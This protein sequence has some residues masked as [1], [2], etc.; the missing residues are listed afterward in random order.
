MK[1]RPTFAQLRQHKELL[2]INPENG[3]RFRVSL[4]S[5]CDCLWFVRVYPYQR[6]PSDADNPFVTAHRLMPRDA[7]EEWLERLR[8]AR[9]G[10]EQKD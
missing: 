10:T 6:H 4:R 5:W 8:L 3:L 1:P 7:I 2:V 9:I